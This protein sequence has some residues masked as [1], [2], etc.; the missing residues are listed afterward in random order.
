VLP[1]LAARLPD[2]ESRRLAFGLAASVAMADRKTHP[3]EMS[4]LKALQEAFEISEAEV[5]K[6]VEAAEAHA[7]L[8]AR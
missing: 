5:V 7:P 6:L 4:V 3:G 8:P 2:P 1:S